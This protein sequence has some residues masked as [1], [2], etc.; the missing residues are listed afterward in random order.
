MNPPDSTERRAGRGFT[1]VFALLAAGLVIASYISY[2]N[3]E[4]RI[5]LT[6]TNVSAVKAVLGVVR[7]LAP[8]SP[9][10]SNLRSDA[11][12]LTAL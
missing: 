1:L 4:L 7:M 2:R 6:S 11:T 9:I 12:K 5:P 3:Y 10:R 8:P